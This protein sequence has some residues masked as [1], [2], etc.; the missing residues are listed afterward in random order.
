MP[1]DRRPACG[2]ASGPPAPGPALRAAIRPLAVAVLLVAVPLAGCLGGAG[3]GPDAPANVAQ[4][5]T[6]GPEAVNASGISDG[7]AHVH[8]RWDGALAKTLMDDTVSTASS[9]QV[10]PGQTLAETVGCVFTC[11]SRAPFTLPEGSIVPPGTDRLEVSVSWQ[12]D[13]PPVGALTAVSLTYVPADRAEPDWTSW[14]TSPGTWTINTTVEM[15][16]GGHAQHSLWRFAVNVETWIEA[17]DGTLVTSP[18][19]IAASGMAFDVQVRALRDDVSL[20]LEPPHPDHWRNGSSWTVLEGTWSGEATSATFVSVEDRQGN[21]A[22]I[23]GSNHRIIPPGTETLVAVVNWTNGSP[24]EQVSPSEAEI[25]WSN[26]FGF[27]TTLQPW[28]PA[29]A[30]DGRYV[31]TMPVADNMTDGLYADRSRWTFWISI[32]GQ[33]VGPASS[34]V[35]FDVEPPYRFEGT[36]SVQITAYNSPEPPQEVL[37]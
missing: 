3:G 37:S 29:V 23:N 15:A 5:G 34:A 12:D 19:R 27:F 9:V 25:D 7:Q 36:W 24:T 11:G 32:D 17:P 28:E 8:D 13:D 31:F 18:P 4:D 6:S 35:G 30:E 22:W 14:R 21:D 2:T 10:R 26:R 33:E 1:A 20:P 16:D